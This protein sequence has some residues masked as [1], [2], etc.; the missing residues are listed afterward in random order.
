MFMGELAAK[1]LRSLF[2]LMKPLLKQFPILPFIFLPNKTTLKHQLVNCPSYH[3]GW[4]LIDF[5]LLI[6][7]R[8]S[9]LID[10]F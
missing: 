9:S 2:A 5:A 8:Y 7:A 1:E 10:T 6:Q 4:S 3:W